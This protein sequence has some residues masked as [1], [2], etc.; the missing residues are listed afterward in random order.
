MQQL[1]EAW[2]LVDQGGICHYFDV[3]TLLSQS[4]VTVSNFIEVL[5]GSKIAAKLESE[6]VETVSG[7]LP[8]MFPSVPGGEPADGSLILPMLLPVVPCTGEN[9]K[10]LPWVQALQTLCGWNLDTTNYAYTLTPGLWTTAGLIQHFSGPRPNGNVL[11][12]IFYNLLGDVEI[13]IP[14]NKKG[15]VTFKLAGAHYSEQDTAANTGFTGENLPNLLTYPK[16]A[17]TCQ[18]FKN[19]VCLIG[20][21]G[22][23]NV[24][25]LKI[26]I[27]SPTTVRTDSSEP[28]G[29]GFTEAQDRKITTQIKI[30][31]DPA[32][33]DITTHPAETWRTGATAFLTAGTTLPLSVA[34]GI[35]S[36]TTLNR[37]G[38]Y[39]RIWQPPDKQGNA[40]R[41]KR[42]GELDH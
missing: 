36:N 31:A 29:I 40:R 10:V 33:D 27:K 11:Q 41:R 21:Q 42:R 19:A 20:G 32:A 22:G 16:L 5:K 38:I 8:S 4:F 17:A 28:N 14:V 2:F 3:T 37:G 6:A 39:I 25:S 13:D 12:E 26:T 35:S 23:Y 24:I 1:R 7:P 18:A 30:F 9:F 34:Y 15:T